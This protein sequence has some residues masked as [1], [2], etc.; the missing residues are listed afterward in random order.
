M[1]ISELLKSNIPLTGIVKVHSI[2]NSD[3]KIAVYYNGHFKDIDPTKNSNIINN[4]ILSIYSGLTQDSKPCICIKINKQFKKVNSTSITKNSINFRKVTS[5]P[6][7]SFFCGLDFLDTSLWDSMSILG[8]WGYNVSASKGLTSFERHSILS[9]VIIS[10]DMTKKEI[11][12]HLKH[13]INLHIHQKNYQLAI[14]KWKEDITYVKKFQ[15]SVT[16]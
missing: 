7:D 12:N 9:H 16:I 3:N 15:K 5:S 14:K 10:G 1:K 8:V 2:P 4:Q 11:I 13:M 6:F